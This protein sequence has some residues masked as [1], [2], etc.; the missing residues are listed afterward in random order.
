MVDV[1]SRKE[2]IVLLHRWR[3]VHGLNEETRQ[4]SPAG[5]SRDLVFPDQRLRRFF[6]A[7]VMTDSMVFLWTDSSKSSSSTHLLRLR[8]RV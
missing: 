3:K 8:L 7:S 2:K 5:L 6:R 1:C 4:I